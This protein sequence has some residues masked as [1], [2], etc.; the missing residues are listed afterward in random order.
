MPSLRCEFASC[1]APIAW[2]VYRLWLPTEKQIM[3]LCAKHA[4]KDVQS[5][6]FRENTFYRYEPLREDA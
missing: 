5:G 4:P 6:K 2:R 3:H 1:R